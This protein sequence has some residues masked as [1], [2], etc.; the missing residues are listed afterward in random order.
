MET[1]GAVDLDLAET[2]APRVR[3]ASF[4]D[5]STSSIGLVLGVDVEAERVGLDGAE[6]VTAGRTDVD[7]TTG[8]S[9]LAGSGPVNAVT[10]SD[11]TAV[12]AKVKA[13]VAICRRVR[14]VAAATGSEARD[15]GRLEATMRTGSAVRARAASSGSTKASS[16]L[17]TSSN[18]DGTVK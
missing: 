4:L 5:A 2:A 1:V 15:K 13:G 17:T 16:G 8:E 6:V 9:P 18:G 3:T 11:A 14:G 10:I 7:S 12:A